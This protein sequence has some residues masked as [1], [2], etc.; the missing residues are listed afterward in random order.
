MIPV[1]LYCWQ[2]LQFTLRTSLVL[3]STEGD[4]VKA[5]KLRHLA[6]EDHKNCAAYDEASEKSHTSVLWM[7][8]N[9]AGAGIFLWASSDCMSLLLLPIA[10]LNAA[11]VAYKLRHQ[12][13][14]TYFTT[15]ILADYATALALYA[16]ICA[17][18]IVP[19]LLLN[20]MW[21][22]TVHFLV[23]LLPETWLTA[24]LATPEAIHSVGRR[25]FEFFFIAKLVM[26][27]EMLVNYRFYIDA[28]YARVKQRM[29]VMGHLVDCLYG[30]SYTLL[31]FAT[32]VGALT[33]ILRVA[34]DVGPKSSSVVGI[35]LAVWL[36]QPFSMSAM[37]LWGAVYFVLHRLFHCKQFFWLVHKEHHFSCHQSCLTA[38]SESGLL[39]APLEIA[40]KDLVGLFVP[41]LDNVLAVFG[42]F[43]NSL[44]HHYYDEYRDYHW[45]IVKQL[46]LAKMYARARL[47][48]LCVHVFNVPFVAANVQFP[49][50]R[51]A[52]AHL[53]LGPISR[54]W[55][56]RHHWTTE[57]KYG[58]GTFDSVLRLAKPKQERRSEPTNEDD[59]LERFIEAYGKM[60]SGVVLT[61]SNVN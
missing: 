46:T 44:Q 12:L 36:R 17:V 1:L 59:T 14:R 21:W 32:N 15:V 53:G 61:T 4:G 43:T 50:E 49:L 3:N 29:D 20:A 16:V 8:L 22:R 31:G 11:C 23:D 37:R 19:A 48:S 45:F 51:F 7:L 6:K 34:A 60:L 54:S 28:L 57:S 52:P 35:L 47:D 2:S 30:F 41:I 25:S 40:G 39:E 38:C 18:I 55:H 58:Y 33:L 10:A 56:G 24:P 42:A 13:S 27:V 5:E 9:V 26:L